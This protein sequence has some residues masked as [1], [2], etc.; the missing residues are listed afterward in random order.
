MPPYLFPSILEI[1]LF[2]F[3]R[4][5]QLCLLF[6]AKDKKYADAYFSFI[7]GKFCILTFPM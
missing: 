3:L 7:I 1:F 6:T 5:L 2:T 4:E